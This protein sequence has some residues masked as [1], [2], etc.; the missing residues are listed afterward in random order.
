MASY[1]HNYVGPV[2][3]VIEPVGACKS[4][5]QMFFELAARFPFAQKYCKGVDEWLQLLC[6]PIW[7]QG[8]DLATL[9]QGAF[10]LDA[11]MVPYEDKVFPTSSGQFQFMTEFSP[12]EGG[13]QGISLQVA[14]HCAPWVH[15]F[16]AHC[17]R[18]RVIAI[19]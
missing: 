8:V 19:H 9:R 4:E 17:C 5:F 6:T 7:E 1:G 14:D 10:R 3:Q 2:N 18:A 12:R 11:P 15:L 16:R 13:L